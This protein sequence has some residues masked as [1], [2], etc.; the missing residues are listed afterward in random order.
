VFEVNIFHGR[1]FDRFEIA[2]EFALVPPRVM[3]RSFFREQDAHGYS[4]M[5]PDGSAFH[6]LMNIC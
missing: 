2:S 3:S 5:A 1:V 6:G 4:K